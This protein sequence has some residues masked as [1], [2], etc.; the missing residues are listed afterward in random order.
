MEEKLNA[1][2]TIHRTPGKNSEVL[3]LYSKLIFSP[4]Q[5][6]NKKNLINDNVRDVF[7]AKKISNLIK[8]DREG[9]VDGAYTIFSVLCI[10]LWCRSFVDGKNVI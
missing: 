2:P 3:E 9:R 1:N 6:G 8:M 10:E 5:E 7:D 4:L